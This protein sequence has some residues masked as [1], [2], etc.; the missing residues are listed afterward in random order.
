MMPSD[1]VD[2]PQPDSPTM[3]MA[4]PGMTEQ[5]KSITA[6]I[7]APGEEGDRQILDLDDRLGVFG[8]GGWD[9]LVHGWLLGWH[10]VREAPPS[11]L[12]DISPSRGEITHFE[13]SDK[14]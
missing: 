3:P 14:S 4:S 11:V 5:E 9:D 1:T 13:V 10:S 6:G 2:L 8:G 12:P 7:A